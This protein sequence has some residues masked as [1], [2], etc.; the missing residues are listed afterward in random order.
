[1]E[2]QLEE[3][4]LDF[5]QPTKEENIW[6]IPEND[7][8]KKDP[9]MR[10][11]VHDFIMKVLSDYRDN[12]PAKFNYTELFMIGGSTTFNYS[13]TSDIDINATIDVSYKDLG[14]YS[15]LVPRG[16]L[17]P[18]TQ[19]PV[20][21]FL[22]SKD[23]VSMP[24]NYQNIYNLLTSHWDKITEIEISDIPYAYITEVADF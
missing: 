18:G 9:Q 7:P 10:P 12:A 2:K 6:D 4:V 14:S 21:V 17:V 23:D 20:N 24:Q 5:R 11:E 1:M 19:H 3:S 13:P 16:I 22:Q 8:G 15:A